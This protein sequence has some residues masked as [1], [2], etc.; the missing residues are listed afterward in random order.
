MQASFGQA[1]PATI[2]P[3]TAG[4]M[5]GRAGLTVL[6][7]ALLLLFNALPVATGPV[8]G[9]AVPDPVECPARTGPG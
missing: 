1:R 5:A 3:V 7:L 6:G 8:G 2:Q 4:R 9:G